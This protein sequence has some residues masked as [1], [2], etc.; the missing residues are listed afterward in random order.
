[1]QAE[2]IDV[3]Y[4]NNNLDSSISPRLEFLDSNI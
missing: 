3:S 4:K 1:M 2:I